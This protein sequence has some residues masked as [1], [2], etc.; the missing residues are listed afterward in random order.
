MLHRRFCATA[1]LPMLFFSYRL[2]D[3]DSSQNKTAIVGTMNSR[4]LRLIDD[5]DYINGKMVN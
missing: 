5:T 2:N 4:S 1:I 3:G